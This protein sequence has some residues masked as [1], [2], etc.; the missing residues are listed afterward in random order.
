MAEAGARRVFAL[1]GFS[2]TTGFANNCVGVLGVEPTDAEWAHVVDW[3]EALAFSRY[4]GGWPERLG[5]ALRVGLN[6]ETVER[7]LEEGN[8]VTWDL[9]EVDAT[10]FEG[11]GT[12]AGAVEAVLEDILVHPGM[13]EE[14]LKCLRAG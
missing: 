13:P 11:E 3:I 14:Q 2:E 5:A 9:I 7:W 1:M 6:V 10:E 12:L 4:S 8:G